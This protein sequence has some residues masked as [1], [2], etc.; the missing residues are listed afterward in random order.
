SQVNYGGS[1]DAI[2]LGVWKQWN[3]DL[4]GIGGLKSVSSLTIGVNS[5][6]SGRLYIDDIRLYREAP[7]V[8]VPVDPGNNGLAA[9]YSFEGN[10]QDVSGKGLHGTGQNDP[11]Y[12]AGVVGQAISLDGTNDY[13]ELP[14]GNLISSSASM[15]ISTWVNWSGATGNWQ[16]IFDF[17][18]GTANYM[19]LTPTASAG[20]TGPLRFAIRQT[21]S[22]GESQAN[23]P[24]TLPTGWHHVAVVIDGDGMM[25]YL[26]LDGDLVGSGATLVL[27]R[28]LGVTTQNWLGRSQFTADSYFNGQLDEFRIYNR[29]LSAAEVRYLA[30]DRP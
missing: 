18:T 16:R 7:E 19:F 9:A 29:A 22:T 21:T 8:V 2:K 27:P 6:G 3:I 14:I 20:M 15:T 10:C 12:V 13:V 24:R 1:S 28:D 4:S 23:A 25:M 26:Y 17:G 30:G 5:S 11:S